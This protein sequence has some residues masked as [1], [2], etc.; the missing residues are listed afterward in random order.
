[1]SRVP[2]L[3]KDARLIAFVGIAHALLFFVSYGLLTS[4]PGP[5]ASDAELQAFYGSAN[6]YRLIVVGLYVM[7][8][9]GIAFLWFTVALREW[10]RPARHRGAEIL[11]GVQLAS[12]ILYVGLFFA[13]AASSSVMAISGAHADAPVDPMV[14]RQFPQYSATLLL[15]F[16]MRVAATFV[17]TTSQI[18]RMTGTLP[19]WFASLGW[20]VGIALLLSGPFH[21]VLTLVLPLWQLALC[22][23]ILARASRPH[24][25]LRG[26][27][28]DPDGL[29][30]SS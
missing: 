1:V 16:V 23:V 10:M 4:S 13:A 18:G 28:A 24:D 27:D 7:P 5:G 8:F 11:S 25:E 19:R 30:R 12:G 2:D 29:A 14:Q 22:L 26:I 20:I 9:A 21:R 6:R 15:V 17:L 3:R